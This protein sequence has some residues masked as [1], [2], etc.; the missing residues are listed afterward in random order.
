MVREWNLV[1][2]PDGEIVALRT[3]L[4]Q[5]ASQ[6]V[7]AL[8]NG[9]RRE[10]PALAEELLSTARRQF[11]A[12]ERRLRDGRAPSLLRHAH[13]HERFLADLTALAGLAAQGD[14]AG[15]AALRPER[16]IPAWLTAHAR[17]DRDLAV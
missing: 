3:Q 14:D 6:L 9:G 4:A 2:C 17:T 1:A 12:E 11:A 8:G 16:W 15:L 13:E 10:L 5:G 7:A